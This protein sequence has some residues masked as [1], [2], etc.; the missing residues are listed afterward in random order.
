MAKLK[1]KRQSELR[2]AT[3]TL[4]TSDQQSGSG[5]AGASTPTGA[6]PTNAEQTTASSGRVVTVR[7]KK[8]N[9]K[10]QK[11]KSAAKTAVKGVW[12]AGSKA[13]RT[14]KMAK[15]SVSKAKDRA[16]KIVKS[17]DAAVN[18]NGESPT[19]YAQGAVA[20]AGSVV[21]GTV[22]S[23]AAER[24]VTAPKRAVK[25]IYR[26][27]RNSRKAK[28]VGEVAEKAKEVSEGAAKT[29]SQAAQEAKEAARAASDAVKISKNAAETAKTAN[30]AAK[31]AR[32]TAKA[33]AKNAGK[34]VGRKARKAVR[35]HA[36]AAGKGAAKT[37]QTAEK[38]A[39]AAKSSVETAKSALNT[40]KSSVKAAKRSLSSAKKSIKT[41]KET[42]KYAT[43][44]F[45]KFTRKG[46]A[47]A[48]N[49]KN[50]IKE[51]KQTVKTA[52]ESLRAAKASV[53][54]ARSSIKTAQS[55]ANTAKASAKAANAAAKTA[56][57]MA[58]KAAQTAANAAK[59]AAKV[60]VKAA[61]AAAHALVELAHEL[62][63]LI[64]AGGW[65]V[66][67]IILIAA[68][69]GALVYFG[70][71][72][73][74]VDDAENV[75]NVRAI[76]SDAS[77]DYSTRKYEKI[78]E[79]ESSYSGQYTTVSVSEEAIDW[80]CVLALYAA[81]QAANTDTSTS[82]SPLSSIDRA[83][84]C[85]LYWQT[86]SFTSWL[87]PE[88]SQPPTI[89]PRTDSKLQI[90]K[91][92]TNGGTVAG[93]HF[94]VYQ[95]K[96]AGFE[97]FD[98]YVSGSDGTITTPVL[99]D[100][101]YMIVQYDYPSGMSDAEKAKWSPVL[102]GEIKDSYSLKPSELPDG[103]K[104]VLISNGYSEAVVFEDEY[105]GEQIITLHISIKRRNV[106]EVADEIGLTA[107]QTEVLNMLLS[108]E[109]S[110]WWDA[111]LAG[112]S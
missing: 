89:S 54:T 102:S 78:T 73:F 4:K 37:A 96:R 52:K 55:S 47:A 60:T 93:W 28:K 17:A 81:K 76:I 90:V 36:H 40:A 101:V 98:T 95:G 25:K 56:A 22:A 68:L 9:P 44:G 12:K 100:G 32:E 106:D 23:I 64:A 61:H 82:V 41:A 69:L 26:I 42:K 38:A 94:A 66:L 1:E 14:A 70:F 88:P 49:A 97:L 105:C 111:L 19:D 80:R 29:A 53:K 77:A 13:V 84:F 112:A 51:S 46:R 30:A 75:S 35:E 72:L 59:A 11:I 79:I 24:V 110:E 87:N 103:Y 108:D 2:T 33:T 50:V 85:D 86:A 107:D 43:K 83:Y 10:R 58:A 7:V 92:A 8:K 65:V 31:G 3:H 48:K 91:T 6:P 16:E 39:N 74:M 71:S 67:L 62:F 15:F 18:A 99:S 5:T 20:N 21:V 45:R 57:K 63:A 27:V 34:A 109:C 104:T